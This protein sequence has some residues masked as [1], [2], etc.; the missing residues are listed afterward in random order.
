MFEVN[1]PEDLNFS[2]NIFGASSS[3]GSC[4]VI[5][6]QGNQLERFEATISDMEKGRLSTTIRVGIATGPWKTIASHD[7]K[8]MKIGKQGDV[9]WSQAF[10]TENS[11]NVVASAEW[12]KDQVERVVAIDKEG[13]LYTT[14]HGSVAS[15]KVDQLTASFRNLKLGQIEKFLYQTRPY[16]WIKFNNVSL[17]PG[18]ITRVQV[19]TS[20]TPDVK[21][22][23]EP[24]FT[25]TLP[26]GATVELVG[27]CE[28]PSKGRQWWR[29]DGSLID[30]APYKTMDSRLK[31]HKGYSDYEFVL[32]LKG[33]SDTSYKWQIPGGKQGTDTGAPIDEHGN[34]VSDLRVYTT[35]Q[36]EDKKTALVRIGISA[37]K[38]KTLAS[39][40]V[41]I[42]EETYTLEDGE[43][44]VA[45]GRAYEKED[46]TIVPLTHTLNRGLEKKALRL[47]A[48]T[49]NGKEIRGG[50]WGRGGNIL[51]SNTY[52][53]NLPLRDIKE[54]RFQNRTYQ[55]IEFKNVS[56]RPGM[57]A[58]VQNEVEKSAIQEKEITK[59][60]DIEDLKIIYV[61]ADANGVNNGSS[62][63]NAYRYLQD[64]LA[65]ARSGDEIRIAQG[66]YKPDQGK[67]LTPGDRQATFRMGK[68]TVKGGY[69][70]FS[71]S[72]PDERDI[73]RYESVLSGDLNGD[74]GPNFVNTNDNSSRVT[75]LDDTIL[76]GF[77][78]TGGNSDSSGAGMTCVAAN[79]EIRNCIFRNNAAVHGGVM[80]ISGRKPKRSEGK[81]IGLSPVLTNCK[82]INNS[83]MYGGAIYNNNSSP[84]L[85]NCT[86][87]GNSAVAISSASGTGGAIHNT[88]S[89]PNFINCEF[90]GNSA[91]RGGSIFNLQSHPAFINCT[92]VENTVR[93]TR[94]LGSGNAIY[95]DRS[96]PTLTGCTFNKNSGDEAGAIHNH[97]SNPILTNC[98]FDNI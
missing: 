88:S 13:K 56:L 55:W 93:G 50:L 76:D 37:D 96:N 79:P 7:G 30:K 67:D 44:A 60:K 89:D 2:C 46:Q 57:K 22:E 23:H 47:I 81:F 98:T 24:V 58:D 48:V 8:Q 17:K 54:F 33:P 6:A 59:K 80:Y 36:P 73:T 19:V 21:K 43:N 62:W 18:F 29:P 52:V 31:R 26:D 75:I 12:R 70:G 34:R 15:G 85:R 63:D 90:K 84:T 95:N 42:P 92:F 1:G 38:W 69:A 39:N 28:H 82:F 68:V 4:K 32:R 14:G 3:E 87:V 16:Q 20:S 77:T 25:S 61:D 41:N 83:A 72:D 27:V 40:P 74:D 65:V 11:T 94:R 9:L 86:F 91:T 66:V 51:S 10:Q 35:N 78:I 97:E 45:F 64:A 49:K 71:S 53:F 5:D